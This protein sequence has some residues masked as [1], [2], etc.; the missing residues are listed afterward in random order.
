MTI[1]NQNISNPISKIYPQN[2]PQSVLISRAPTMNRYIN[3]SFLNNRS[4]L[5]HFKTVCII[6]LIIRACIV[7]QDLPPHFFQLSI[8]YFTV[9]S[10]RQK[11]SALEYALL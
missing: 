6:Q 1:S 10:I 11:I 3:Q 8:Y 5:G 2:K 9:Y 4:P 7:E